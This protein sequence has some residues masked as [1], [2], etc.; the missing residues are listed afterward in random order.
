MGKPG[1]EDLE[2]AIIISNKTHV[3]RME[4]IEQNLKQLT[5]T[6]IQSNQVIRKLYDDIEKLQGRVNELES[7][8]KQVIEANKTANLL[9]RKNKD[10]SDPNLS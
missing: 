5:D 2:R 9:L 1:Y 6:M 3:Q 8:A 7:F 10:Q 4:K